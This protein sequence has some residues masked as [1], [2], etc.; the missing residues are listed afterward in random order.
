[1]P[2]LAYVHE[3]FTVD[4]CHASIQ[5]LRWQERPLPGPRCQSPGGDPWGTEH[6][7]P[8]GT[9]DWCNGGPRTVKARTTT[10]LHHRTRAL[11][12]GRLAAFRLCLSCASRRIARE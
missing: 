4:P 6:D 9:R 8:G 2:V 3:L 11:P 5:T 7:R 12:F 1:M 10:L